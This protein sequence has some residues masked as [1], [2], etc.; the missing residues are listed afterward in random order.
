MNLRKLAGIVILS[1]PFLSTHAAFASDKNSFPGVDCSNGPVYDIGSGVD[2]CNPAFRSNR[3]LYSAA[4]S[5][6]IPAVP[7]M[8][9]PTILGVP[10]ATYFTYT[11]D[12]APFM[13]G[14]QHDAIKQ[15]KP[16]AP[17]VTVQCNKENDPNCEAAIKEAIAEY[18]KT[19][20]AR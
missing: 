18:Q 8:G 2:L 20:G 7:F 4:T 9:A 6:L 14:D 10:A 12:V 13:A 16:M 11:N 5:W 1:I 17:V 15:L 19:K 3:A